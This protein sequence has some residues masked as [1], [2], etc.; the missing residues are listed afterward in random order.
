MNLGRRDFIKTGSA[1]VAGSMIIPPFLKSCQN[2]QI[3]DEREKLFR[4]F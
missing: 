3:S 2:I 1:A 4:S